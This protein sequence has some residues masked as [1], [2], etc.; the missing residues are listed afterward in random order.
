MR[1]EGYRS[2]WLKG[3]MLGPAGSAT[4][5]MGTYPFWAGSRSGSGG[6]AV[7][8]FHAEQFVGL[9]FATGQ[10][11]TRALQIL[12]AIKYFRHG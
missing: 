9:H 4:I 7:I 2:R 5:S 1:L 11:R 8:E 6:E 3:I 12:S 10:C